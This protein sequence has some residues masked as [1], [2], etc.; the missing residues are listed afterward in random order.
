MTVAVAHELGAERQELEP[1]L[2][3]ADF[4]IVTCSLTPQTQGMFSAERFALMKR[5]AIFI[6]TGRGG[7]SK[8]FVASINNLPY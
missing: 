1:L 5:T 3:E 7:Y 4:V 8:N 2:V 6:N